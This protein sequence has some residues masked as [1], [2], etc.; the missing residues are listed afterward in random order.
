MKSCETPA[1]IQG[2]EGLVSRVPLQVHADARG[3][4]KPIE[5]VDLPFTPRRVFTVADV[6]AGTVRGEHGHHT[7]QQLLVA[8]QGRI[9]ILL[10]YKQQEASVVLL[11]TEPGL[12]LHAGVWCRQTY[13]QA[14][15]VLLVLA[16]DAYDP[17]SYFSNW[18]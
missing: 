8:L 4:L 13:A 1:A 5:F 3:C 16:S 17:A 15:S 10:R 2:F 9:D 6:P 18:T 12:L 14:H 7:G 11:P